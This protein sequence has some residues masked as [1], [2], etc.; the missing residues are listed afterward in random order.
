VV[1]FDHGPY[2][3][4]T[5]PSRVDV[6]VVHRFLSEESYWGVGRPRETVVRS[7][8]NSHLVVGAY[9]DGRQVGFARMVTDLATFAWLCDVFVVDEAR[10]SGVGAAL[11]GAIVEHPDASDIKRQ[12]L[13]TR[14][15]H[16]LYAKFGYEPLTRP[17]NWMIR[18]APRT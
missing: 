10:G 9:R 16:G 3:I 5:D 17:E 15:A 8:A 1:E 11:V 7:I 14:D 12:F 2:T 13:A 6:D 4:S 18:P